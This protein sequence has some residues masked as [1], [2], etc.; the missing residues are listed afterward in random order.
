MEYLELGSA[1]ADEECAQVG[2]DGYRD[3]ALAQCDAFIKLIVRHL[4]PPP[5]SARLA[6]KAFGHDFGTYYE[7]V[8]YYGDEAGFDY[9]LK[10]ESE[11]PTTWE[12]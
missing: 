12:G 2:E 4:G 1:P 3:K 9:A 11:A 8:C 6:T 10:C 7:V 5:G